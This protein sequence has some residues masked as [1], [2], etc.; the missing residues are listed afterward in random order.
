MIITFQSF[1]DIA[2]LFDIFSRQN[3]NRIC[4]VLSIWLFVSVAWLILLKNDLNRHK[5][6]LNQYAPP[7]FDID[8]EE[9]YDEVAKAIDKKWQECYNASRTTT[10]TSGG[11]TTSRYRD[12]Y[13]PKTVKKNNSLVEMTI[14]MTTEGMVMLDKTPPGGYYKVALD[15]KRLSG[16]KAELHWYSAKG[17]KTA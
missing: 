1:D 6:Y 5:K 3:T 9:E 10:R 15:I 13:H 2:H 14:Q 17:W 11:M 12:T 7:G 16:G 4:L 8:Q